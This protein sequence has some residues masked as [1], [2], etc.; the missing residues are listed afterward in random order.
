MRRF[1]TTLLARLLLID[2]LSLCTTA[3]L[4]AAN[5]KPFAERRVVLQISDEQASKQTLVL[6]SRRT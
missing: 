5:D 4:Q 2:A 6:A 1:S 3:S